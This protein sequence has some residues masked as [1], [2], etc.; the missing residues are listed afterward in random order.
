MLLQ[1]APAAIRE[2]SKVLPAFYR[3]KWCWQPVPCRVKSELAQVHRDLPLWVSTWLGPWHC[4]WELRPSTFSPPP[5]QSEPL[6][7]PETT[8]RF[9]LEAPGVTQVKPHQ[10]RV[11]KMRSLLVFLLHRRMALT[12]T[13]EYTQA[14]NTN[15]RWNTRGVRAEK[16][17]ERALMTR[18]PWRLRAGPWGV[19]PRGWTVAGQ[20][21]GEV[22]VE[23]DLASGDYL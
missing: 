1:R 12:R 16:E 18:G 20:D 4:W 15:N 7:G 17:P 13:R 3:I 8:R 2:L 11:M 19:H 22:G 21:P 23:E 9:P 5:K 6:R 14:Y 10:S